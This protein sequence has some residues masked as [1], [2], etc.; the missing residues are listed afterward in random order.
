[1]GFVHLE[2]HRVG[3]LERIHAGVTLGH[4]PFAP[5]YSLAQLAPQ[6]QVAA[7]PL[8]EQRCE[9]VVTLELRL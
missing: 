3:E 4:D 7:E 2:A 8:R 9:T 1:M 5:A 6:K